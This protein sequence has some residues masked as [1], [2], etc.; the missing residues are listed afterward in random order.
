MLAKEVGKGKY[1]EEF[2][3]AIDH[4]L[5]LDQTKRPTNIDDWLKMMRQ[6]SSNIGTGSETVLAVPNSL[7]KG[8]QSANDVSRCCGLKECSKYILI[9]VGLFLLI[10][11]L[12]IFTYLHFQTTDIS[13][14]ISQVLPLSSKIVKK[15]FKLIVKV[16]PEKSRIKILNITPKYKPGMMLKP[17]NYHIE[18]SHPGYKTIRKWIKIENKDITSNVELLKLAVK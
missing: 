18:V 13:K 7:E 8:S 1:P 11:P 12:I 17:D 5:L 9:A 16:K 3:N 6:K 4:A 2:L 14:T 10:Q 15:E